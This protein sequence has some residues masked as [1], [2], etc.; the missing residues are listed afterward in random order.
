MPL[1][2]Q[3]VLNALVRSENLTV[4]I[5][6]GNH[7]EDRLERKLCLRKFDHLRR[8]AFLLLV[9][10]GWSITDAENLTE[11]EFELVVQ[12]YFSRKDPSEPL[13]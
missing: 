10:E 5:E 1:N 9:E 7:V 4:F 11:D 8:F 3:T 13:L 6:Y 2:P 12:R